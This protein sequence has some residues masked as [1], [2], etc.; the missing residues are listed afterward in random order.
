M[1]VATGPDNVVAASREQGPELIFNLANTHLGQTVVD[2]GHALFVTSIV[3]AMI[4]FH[5]TT[6]RYMFALG[7]ERV[8]PAALGRTSRRSG[9]PR[10]ASLLQSFIGIAVIVIYA[11]AGWDPLV[12]LFFWGGTSGALGVLV[13]IASTSIAVI[14][15][16]AKN[17]SGESLWHRVIA[18]A[19]ATVALLAIVYLALDNFATLLGVAPDHVL[20][21]LIPVI[22]LGR[23]RARRLLGPDAQAAAARG[24][25]DDRPR[26][27]ERHGQHGRRRS[28]PVVAGDP[29]GLQH[30][31]RAPMSTPPIRPATDAEAGAVADRIA[32]AFVDLDATAWLIPDPA[33]RRHVLRDD[34]RI[35]V[36]HAYEHGEIHVTDDLSAVAVWYFVDDAFPPPPDYD[37]R[38]AEAC[39]PYTERFATLDKLF[40]ANHPHEAHHHLALLAVRPGVQ[41]TGLGTALLQHHHARLDTHGTPGYLEAS[42]PQ[43]R[44]LYARHGYDL[45]EPFHLPDGTPF[46]PMWRAPQPTG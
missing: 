19:I 34:F 41:G 15:F 18:P 23:G 16:F 46:W 43:S 2:I 36:D 22:Y 21:W 39:G 14:V 6:S 31:R 3:A 7:R 33:D 13:L 20:A 44:D 17:P 38:V 28:D 27:Q 42:S 29:G 24:L 1:T 40:E 5:N 10:N 4:S 35:L 11:V 45:H 26:C 30:R 9:A 25:Q 12:Q 32:E 37:R 8:L